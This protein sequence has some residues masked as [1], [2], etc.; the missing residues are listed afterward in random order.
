M[1]DLGSLSRITLGGALIFA[2]MNNLSLTKNLFM[3]K[4][5]LLFKE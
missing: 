4:I 5:D 1:Y 3:A 2:N